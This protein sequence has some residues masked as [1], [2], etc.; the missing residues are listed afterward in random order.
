MDSKIEAAQTRFRENN[1][2][3]SR[4]VL[5]ITTLLPSS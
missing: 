5:E 2:M 3:H 4:G 1:P